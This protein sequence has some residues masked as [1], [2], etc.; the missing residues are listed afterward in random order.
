MKLVGR[1]VLQTFIRHH[2]EAQSAIL[3][4]ENVIRAAQWRNFAEL[5]ATFSSAD[6]VKLVRVL[7]VT[8]F[9]VGGNKFRLISEVA[10]AQGVVRV[11]L[12]LTH[13]EY[14]RE[15]WKAKLRS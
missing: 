15:N 2:A 12:I 9:N 4:W 1:D 3:R 8:V 14:S 7:V 11:L 10:Y 6:Q 5:R 13:E